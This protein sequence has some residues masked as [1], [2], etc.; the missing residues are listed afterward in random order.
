MRA[1]GVLLPGVLF[2]IQYGIGSFSKE[3]FEFCR[4]IKK[5][6]DRILQICLWVLQDMGFATQSFSTFAG[7]PY[8]ID[9]E[10]LIEEGLLTRE[11]C[12]SVDFTGHPAYVEYEKIYYGRFPVLKK[13]FQRFVPDQVFYRFCRRKQVLAGRLWPIY[14]C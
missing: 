14:G 10:T 5:E 1:S 2:T 12:D 3:A 9:L 6:E 7:N 11:E 4:P 13:A 8:F